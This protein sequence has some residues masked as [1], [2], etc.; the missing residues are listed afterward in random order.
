MRCTARGVAAPAEGAGVSRGRRALLWGI[1]C[2]AVALRFWGLSHQLPDKSYIEE[3]EFIYTALKYGT[4]DLNPHW[5]FHPPLYSYILFALYTAYYLLG[6][7]AGWF[8]GSRDFILQYLIDPGPFYIIARGASALLTIPAVLLLYALGKEV[9][10]PRCGLAACAFFS[11]MPLA[12]QYSHYGCTEP[13]LVVI[14]LLTALSSVR[15]MRTGRALPLFVAGALAGVAMGTKY[16]GVF[17]IAILFPA[18]GTFRRSASWGALCGALAASAAAFLVVC[19]F[20]ILSPREYLANVSLLLTQPLDVGEYG[21]VKLPNLHIAFALRYMPQGMGAAVA[22]ACLLGLAFLW[23]RHRRDDIL[24]AIIPTAF[25]LVIGRSRLFYDRYMLICYPFF[26]LAAA[27][28]ADAA[29]DWLTRRFFPA[30]AGTGMMRVASTALFAAVTAAIAIPSLIS[31]ARLVEDMIMPDTPFVAARWI[32]A[33]L[34]AGTRILVDSAPVPQ[35]EASILREQRLKEEGPRQGFAYREKSG[36][37]FD[38]QRRAA[39]GRRGFDITRILHPRGFHMVKGGKGYEEEWM[40][41]ELMKARLDALGDYDYALVSAVSAGRYGER[42]K[43][44]ERFRF[45]SDFYTSLPRKGTVVKVFSPAT[46]PCKGPTFT[47]Y[48]LGGAVR[49]RSLTE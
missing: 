14:V 5:F 42:E 36:I 30:R 18:A 17:S 45:M 8:H 6:S 48:R 47:L 39:R 24:I 25:Y 43:L 26:A 28:F 11:V 12:V 4:G 27:A 33:H 38:L 3:D 16:T 20:L 41:P 1:V 23:I 13:L 7:A 40:T 32:T 10:S 35:S 2:L 44:P 37:Y 15:A 9:Y 31:S 34:P 49:L 46:Y 21:W 22:A 19:P 29:V